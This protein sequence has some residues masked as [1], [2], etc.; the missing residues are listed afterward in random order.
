MWQTDSNGNY[1]ISS[2]SEE[3]FVGNG[4]AITNNQGDF[5]F[6]TILPYSREEQTS[7]HFNVSIIHKEFGNVN[8]QIYFPLH[9]ANSNDIMLNSLDK[10]HQ[11]LLTSN[12]IPVDKNNF[13]LGYF[14]AFDITLNGISNYRS[15]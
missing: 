3:D 11:T 15:L 12:L 2:N 1:K 10:F 5:E 9:I 4:T 8:T 14:S 6:I 13:N 7:P